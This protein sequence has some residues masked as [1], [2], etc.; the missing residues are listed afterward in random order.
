MN[1]M[2][3]PSVGNTENSLTPDQTAERGQKIYDEKLKAILEP[4]NNGKFVAIE[5][6]T[7]DYFVADTLLEAL[8]RAKEKYP[9][10]VLHTVRIGYE[11]V[12]KMGTYALKGM[13]YGW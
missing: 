4:S 10:K 11:G 9:T 2:S 12:F 8:Q 3:N 5:I 13:S 6:E 7:G 1:C